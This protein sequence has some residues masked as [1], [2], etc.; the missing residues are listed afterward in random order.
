[1]W[2]GPALFAGV[3]IFLW[4]YAR[5]VFMPEVIARRLL[6]YFPYL[7]DFELVIIVN[8]ALAY[9]AV[10]FVF[11]LYWPSLKVHLK[12]PFLGAMALLGLNVFV[13]YPLIG[14]GLFGYRLPQG[15]IAATL[16]LFATHWL[17]ARGLQFQERRSNS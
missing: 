6:V 17:F 7:G 5:T 13:I 2:M 14:R 1:M 3:S 10:Y 11:A 15:W 16:P 4:R 9:F 12:N 8:V